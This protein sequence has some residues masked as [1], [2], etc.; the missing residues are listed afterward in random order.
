MRSKSTALLLFLLPLTGLAQWPFVDVAQSIG[1]TDT[2]SGYPWPNAPFLGTGVSAIDFN[3]DGWDDLTMTTGI[4]RDLLFYLNNGDG[5]FTKIPPLVSNTTDTRMPLWGDIDNDGDKDLF[6]TS[7]SGADRLYENLGG[8]QFED[9]TE[10]AGLQINE[11]CRTFGA[12]FGDYNRDGYLD[13]YV[14]PRE[15]KD[16]PNLLYRNNGDNTFTEVGWETQAHD[17]FQLTHQAIFADYNN[18]GEQ[19]IYVANDRAYAN[20]MYL[21]NG[22]GAY[23]DISEESGTGIVVCAMNVGTGDF[24]HDGY[25][26]IMVTN[27]A[28]TGGNVFLRNNGDLTFSDITSTVDVNDN[29]F[30]W[31]A[32]FFD[33]DNDRDLDLY[34]SS[35]I[36]KPIAPNLLYMNMYYPAGIEDF[37]KPYPVGFPG[38]TVA[39]YSNAILDFNNDGK[40]DIVV[41]NNQSY[42]IQFWKN[43]V[44]NVNKYL[45]FTL[46]GVISNRDGVGTTIEVYAGNDYLKRYMFYGDAYLCQNMDKLHFGLG[47]KT[48]ADSV[49]VT[50]L[51]GIQDR[52]YNVEANQTIHLVENASNTIPLKIT[53]TDA[54]C[55]G[56]ADGAAEVSIRY[57][58]PPFNIQ[59]SNGDTGPAASGLAAGSYVVTVTGADG[60]RGVA[61]FQINEPEK[62][63]ISLTPTHE[64]IGS[65]GAALSQVSGGVQPYSYAWSNGAEAPNLEGVEAGYYNLSVTDANGCSARKDVAIYNVNECSPFLPTE[66]VTTIN[67]AFLKWDT[68]P[69]ADV[70]FIKYR[71]EGLNV[72]IDSLFTQSTGQYILGLD[73]ATSYE[74]QTRTECLGGDLTDWSNTRTFLTRN[75]GPGACDIWTPLSLVTDN[76][77]CIIQWPIE[78]EASQYQIRYRIQDSQDPW[79]EETS[80]YPLITLGPLTYDALYEFQAATDCPYGTTPWSDTLYTFHMTDNYA[81]EG[82]SF[83][84]MDIVSQPEKFATSL[85]VWPNPARDLVEISRP[86]DRPSMLLL[87][88][89]QGQTI[90]Q[91]DWQSK[92]YELRLGKYPLG[93]Y[94][95]IWIEADGTIHNQQIVHI[96]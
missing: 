39:S 82:N 13:L 1:I 10:E 93:L 11:A 76:F 94:R 77:L 2:V 55:L 41:P 71:A 45:I 44:S 95:L 62:I 56:E 25:M 91:I 21:H 35:Q 68:L 14:T 65:D 27:N 32:N 84:K 96:P 26:D 28:S 40:L 15:S 74:Y 58:A 90:E 51:S 33:F 57:G 80:V 53:I 86:D 42:P 52:Y 49:V 6:V 38:D 9:I 50:W 85:Q 36:P 69:G 75:Q 47:N 59:W 31:G 54:S 20:S 64:N 61:Y 89:Q 63:G 16:F 18:D 4:N 22:Q 73:A 60:V 34:V 12:A 46:E 17:N 37:N 81:W 30:C 87:V 78:A 29:Y 8:L 67:S 5:T 23:E 24:N 92:K 72:W 88:N 66:E 7:F 70:Y 48:M 3:D 43:Q 79:T 19:D 83:P